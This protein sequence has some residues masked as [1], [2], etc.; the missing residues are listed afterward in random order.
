[1]RNYIHMFLS[2]TRSYRAQRIESDIYFCCTAAHEDGPQAWRMGAGFPVGVPAVL[3]ALASTFDKECLMDGM[4]HLKDGPEGKP[5]LRMA[6]LA[7][8]ISK[9]CK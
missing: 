3:V 4:M 6:Q 7:F 2:H 8:G 9:V 5:R 1:M